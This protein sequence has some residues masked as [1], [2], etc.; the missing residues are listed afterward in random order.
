MMK[1]HELSVIIAAIIIA[2]GALTTYISVQ[3]YHR[4]DAPLEQLAEEIVKDATGVDVD[5]TL[6]DE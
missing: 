2:I 4:N 6:G 5:F 3:I 1:H